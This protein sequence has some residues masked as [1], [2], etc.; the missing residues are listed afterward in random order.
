M[1]PAPAIASSACSPR[2]IGRRSACQAE[3]GD[4]R[5]LDLE[6]ILVLAPDLVVTW[7]VRGAGAVGALV[8]RGVPVF[9]AN[10]AT[11]DGIA[12]DLERLGTLAGT[13]PTAAARGLRVPGATRAARDRY[14]GATT[15]RCVLRD[16]ELASL[17]DRRTPPD[18]AGARRMRRR[19]RLR[20]APAAGAGRER[21][22][23]AGGQARRH[24]R[25]SGPRRAPAMAR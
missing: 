2:P 21:R 23:R 19:E 9:V 11:I 25:R 12:Q 15:V 17:H 13:L 18:L 7:P 8:E 14:R 4:S 10:P 1:P 20:I 3:V 24:H 22:G 16:L 6:R 5:A